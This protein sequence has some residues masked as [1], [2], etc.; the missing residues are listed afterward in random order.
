MNT[1]DDK[2]GCYETQ[3]SVAMGMAEA[4]NS[5][6]QITADTYK[7]MFQCRVTMRLQW[8]C[9]SINSFEVKVHI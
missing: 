9:A 7:K 8:F 1:A 6:E 2:Q 3:I 4:M 5:R